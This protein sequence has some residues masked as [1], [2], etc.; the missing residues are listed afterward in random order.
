V[1][2]AVDV[3]TVLNARSIRE[4]TRE[5]ST[6][7]TVAVGAVVTLVIVAGI[8]RYELQK[9]VAGGPNA[10]STVN[11]VLIA[12]QSRARSWRS[13]SKASGTGLAVAIAKMNASAPRCCI[14]RAGL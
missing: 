5:L 8:R 13:E 1:I 9:A 6:A 11:A 3:V 4:H 12:L 2:V 10:L 14:A 7:Y